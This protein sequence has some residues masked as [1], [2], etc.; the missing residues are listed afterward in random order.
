MLADTITEVRREAKR[1][2]IAW[3]ELV[4]AKNHLIAVEREIR[5]LTDGVR[6]YAWRRHVGGQSGSAPFWRHGFVARFGHR[7]ARGAD[8]TC[9]PGYD[10]IADSVGREY[11][12]FGGDTAGDV[13]GTEVLWEFLLSDYVPWP[14]REKFYWDALE[15]LQSRSTEAHPCELASF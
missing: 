8:F 9:I 2:G 6:Q 14:S 15:M 1:L 11:P 4:A 12:Q 10:L 7:L 3:R 13:S 5:E